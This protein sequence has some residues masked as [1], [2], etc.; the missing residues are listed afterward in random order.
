MKRTRAYR[1]ARGHYYCPCFLIAVGV[2]IKLQG[3]ALKTVQGSTYVVP[4]W[5]SPLLHQ[6]PHMFHLLNIDLM[7]HFPGEDGLDLTLP[8]FTG[9]SAGMETVLIHNR[10]EAVTF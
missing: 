9:P 7:L 3:N 6:H 10:G 2:V 1:N 5:T 4:I 8:G